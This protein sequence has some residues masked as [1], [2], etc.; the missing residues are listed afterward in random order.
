MFKTRNPSAAL[1]AFPCIDMQSPVHEDI[2]YQLQIAVGR[3]EGIEDLKVWKI[4]NSDDEATFAK[5]ARNKQILDCFSSVPGWDGSSDSLAPAVT[6]LSAEGFPF[7]MDGT[8]VSFVHGEANSNLG[9]E[10]GFRQPSVIASCV[11]TDSIGAGAQA[12][13][14][15]QSLA[16]AIGIGLAGPDLTPVCFRLASFQSDGDL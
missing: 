11:K 4:S 1:H 13:C 15:H 6:A 7:P 3:W 10:G 9:V 12:A 14:P 2:L 16:A 8:G 5:R